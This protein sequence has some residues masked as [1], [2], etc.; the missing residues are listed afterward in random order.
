VELKRND[1]SELSTGWK[2][3]HRLGERAYGCLRRRMRG[4]DG[5]GVWGGHVHT[6]VFKTDDQK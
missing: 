1:T 3:T 4:W 5:S 2:R 6:A